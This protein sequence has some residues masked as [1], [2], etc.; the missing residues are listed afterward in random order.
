MPLQPLN[1][2][3]SV[4]GSA[5]EMVISMQKVGCFVGFRRSRGIPIFR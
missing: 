2:Y 1:A 3:Y 4:K 5:K